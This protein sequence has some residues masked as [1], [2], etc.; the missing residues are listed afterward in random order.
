Y[1]QLP[2]FYTALN[3]TPLKDARLLYHSEP[4]ARELGLHYA[5]TEGLR[6]SSI[7]L[8]TNS[9]PVSTPP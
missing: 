3:P 5:E 7:T 2:G 9:Y 1:Q 8:T 4:L 6:R